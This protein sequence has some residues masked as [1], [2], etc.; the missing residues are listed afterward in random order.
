M[1]LQEFGVHLLDCLDDHYMYF[2]TLQGSEESD[3]C[4]KHI[5]DCEC[6][7]ACVA[8]R[9][10]VCFIRIKSLVEIRLVTQSAF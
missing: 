3:T 8:Y 4:F 7:L 10:T 5:D 1:V 2:N 6:M 9:R